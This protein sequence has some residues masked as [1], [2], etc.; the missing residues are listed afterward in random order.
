MRADDMKSLQR[1]LY[2]SL[3]LYITLVLSLP[4]NQTEPFYVPNPVGRGTIQLLSSCTITFGLGIWT[5]IHP[6]IVLVKGRWSNTYYKLSW[7]F[8]AA[9]LP[10]AVVAYAIMQLKQAYATQM[11]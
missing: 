3:V 11:G 8:I 5:A 7:M 2:F 10:E 9:I 6:D 4:I 1:F